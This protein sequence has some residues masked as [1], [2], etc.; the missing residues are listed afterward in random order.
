MGVMRFLDNEQPD[1]HATDMREEMGVMPES[2][3]FSRYDMNGET[4]ADLRP[5]MRRL[6]HQRRALVEIGERRRMRALAMLDV[7]Q[8]QGKDD[9]AEQH[10]RKLMASADTLHRRL[11]E[12]ARHDPDE[13]RVL[14]ADEVNQMARDAPL[15]EREVDRL[16]EHCRR[17]NKDIEAAQVRQM[18]RLLRELDLTDFERRELMAA[19]DDGHHSADHEDPVACT[20]CALATAPG[21]GMTSDHL[22]DAVL[23]S[24]ERAEGNPDWCAAQ[25]QDM[26]AMAVNVP[27]CMG[28]TING[29]TGEFVT[30][31]TTYPADRPM[32]LQTNMPDPQ[33]AAGSVPAAGD[34]RAAGGVAPMAGDVLDPYTCAGAV[35][36]AQP[37]AADPVPDAQFP[38]YTAAGGTRRRSLRVFDESELQLTTVKRNLQRQ[39]VHGPADRKRSSRRTVH[40]RSLTASQTQ[41]LDMFAHKGK[42][43]SY[44]RQ[45][46][47]EQV[48]AMRRRRRLQEEFGNAAP[49]PEVMYDGSGRRLWPQ[50]SQSICEMPDLPRSEELCCMTGICVTEHANPTQMQNPDRDVTAGGERMPR[51][52]PEPPAPVTFAGFVDRMMHEL[53]SCKRLPP[54]E[55]QLPLDAATQNFDLDRDHTLA[56]NMEVDKMGPGCVKECGCHYLGL[57]PTTGSD[58]LINVCNYQ[59]EARCGCMHNKREC[60]SEIMRSW[61]E[62][63]GMRDERGNS[64][65]N[66]LQRRQLRRRN[67]RQ[68]RL[69]QGNFRRLTKFDVK[70]VKHAAEISHAQRGSRLRRALSATEADKLEHF[71]RTFHRGFGSRHKSFRVLTGKTGDRFRQLAVID[72]FH[73]QRRRRLQQGDMTGVTGVHETPLGYHNLGTAVTGGVQVMQPAVAP[74][75]PAAPPAYVDNIVNGAGAQAQAWLPETSTPLPQ[76]P[77]AE[78]TT[79]APLITPLAGNRTA[80]VTVKT[81]IDQSYFDSRDGTFKQLLYMDINPRRDM[82]TNSSAD[83][84]DTLICAT[85]ETPMPAGSAARGAPVTECMN[86]MHWD[87]DVMGYHPNLFDDHFAGTVYCPK[88]PREAFDNHA[89]NE[90]GGSAFETAMA[91]M[92]ENDVDFLQ[93]TP[94]GYSCFEGMAVQE[95]A[96]QEHHDDM[97]GRHTSGEVLQNA[98]RETTNPFGADLKVALT[99]FAEQHFDDWCATDTVCDGFRTKGEQMLSEVEMAF[100]EPGVFHEFEIK[101]RK[102]M[103]HMRSLQTRL[104]TSQGV[105]DNALNEVTERKHGAHSL[106]EAV[107]FGIASGDISPIIDKADDKSGDIFDQI[108]RYASRDVASEDLQWGELRAYHEDCQK[109]QRP[110]GLSADVCEVMDKVLHVLDQKILANRDPRDPRAAAQSAVVTRMELLTTVEQTMPGA[111][112]GMPM[113][114]RMGAGD[115]VCAELMRGDSGCNDRAC[116][117]QTMFDQSGGAATVPRDALYTPNTAAG[118]IRA[119]QAPLLDHEQRERQERIDHADRDMDR[120]RENE[121]AFADGESMGTSMC[122]RMQGRRR[123][124]LLRRARALMAEERRL[125]SESGANEDIEAKVSPLDAHLEKALEEEKDML[126][127]FFPPEEAERRLAALSFDR[128]PSASAGRG[129]YLRNS[130]NL[131]GGV[132]PETGMQMGSLLTDPNGGYI[133]VDPRQGACPNAAALVAA[134]MPDEELREVRE[135]V[136]RVNETLV[137]ARA[138]L[139]EPRPDATERVRQQREDER[140][141]LDDYI[142]DFETSARQV[143]DMART[144]EELRNNQTNARVIADAQA[145]VTAMQSSTAQTAATRPPPRQRPNANEVEARPTYEQARAVEA[146]MDHMRDERRPD[147]ASLVPREARVTREDVVDDCMERDARDSGG[148]VAAAAGDDRARSHERCEQE[149]TAMRENER[150]ARDAITDDRLQNSFAPRHG[151]MQQQTPIPRE[152]QC[153]PMPNDYAGNEMGITRGFRQLL[154]D[155]HRS[156]KRGS[157]R[158]KLAAAQMEGRELY[159][160]VHVGKLRDQRRVLFDTPISDEQ[161]RQ[162]AT[163]SV[164]GLAGGIALPAGEATSGCMPISGE[165]QLQMTDGYDGPGVSMPRDREEALEG[166]GQGDPRMQ[167]AARESGRIAADNTIAQHDAAA[168]VNMDFPNPQD[169]TADDPFYNSPAQGMTPMTDFYNRPRKLLAGGATAAYAGANAAKK[170]GSQTRGRFASK[171]RS[172]ARQLAAANKQ[173][174]KQNRREL[175]HAEL[176]R[177]S[178]NGY[179]PANQMSYDPMNAATNVQPM[180][181]NNTGANAFQLQ[182]PSTMAPNDLTVAQNMYYGGNDPTSPLPTTTPSTPTSS[183]TPYYL[184][185]GYNQMDYLA[186]TAAA[187]VQDSVATAMTTTTVAPAV[188]ANTTHWLLGNDYRYDYVWDEVTQTSIETIVYTG[189]NATLAAMYPSDTDFEVAMTAEHMQGSLNEMQEQQNKQTAAEMNATVMGVFDA[190]MS[191]NG[192]LHVPSYIPPGYDCWQ[193]GT[194]NFVEQCF[195]D[196]YGAYTVQ[197]DFGAVCEHRKYVQSKAMEVADKLYQAIET[198]AYTE[199][200]AGLSRRVRRMLRQSVT[201]DATVPTYVRKLLKLPQEWEFDA[202]R[203]LQDFAMQPEQLFNEMLHTDPAAQSGQSGNADIPSNMPPESMYNMM[204][205]N[206]TAQTESPEDVA[207]MLIGLENS[208]EPSYV[209]AVED[210]LASYERRKMEIYLQARSKPNYLQVLLNLGLNQTEKVKLMRDVQEVVNA[211]E[212]GTCSQMGTQMMQPDGCAALYDEQLGCAAL[213]SV[214]TYWNPFTYQEDV[215]DTWDQPHNRCEDMKRQLRSMAIGGTTKESAPMLAAISQLLQRIGDPDYPSSGFMNLLWK[216]NPR[217]PL[218]GTETA[219][220]H[221][222]CAH[223]YEGT[224]GWGQKRE[225][226]YDD[227]G[228]ALGCDFEKRGSREVKDLLKCPG[229]QAAAAGF[230]DSQNGGSFYCATAKADFVAHCTAVLDF[231]VEVMPTT[232]GTDPTTGMYLSGYLAEQMRMA[233]VFEIDPN[234]KYPWDYEPSE[235]AGSRLARC[236]LQAVRENLPEEPMMDLYHMMETGEISPQYAMEQVLEPKLDNHCN[237]TV[238]VAEAVFQAANIT[239]NCKNF[240]M[241]LKMWQETSWQMQCANRPAKP[242]F[243][244]A[245]AYGAASMEPVC[246]EDVEC[247]LFNEMVPVAEKQQ[248]VNRKVGANRVRERRQRRL[249]IEE[250][251]QRRALKAAE[252]S[253]DKKCITLDGAEYCKAGASAGEAELAKA[254]EEQKRRLEWWEERGIDS[255]AM[256]SNPTKAQRVSRFRTSRKALRKAR[257]ALRRN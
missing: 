97:S 148:R 100:P 21:V 29:T 99:E 245:F 241:T 203:R 67:L 72:K 41:S 123:R 165:S 121:A 211:Q 116:M 161:K 24:A 19:G 81:V 214:A 243:N 233:L 195:D 251:R 194:S 88:D 232:D 256:A 15:D 142:R 223:V 22:R 33:P 197:K 60:M 226:R 143:V 198:K 237:V 5:T 112:P 244:D 95:F 38:T 13:T 28:A 151:E 144:H 101:E 77:A 180:Q 177:L 90:W 217:K 167:A 153:V 250:R 192:D 196:V 79:P 200:H 10:R 51:M 140:E 136:E 191:Y 168:D 14:N 42:P 174:A 216:A 228:N 181:N 83:P 104:G 183:T 186:S 158:R 207:A 235:P 45:L 89:G 152:E 125:L 108:K 127:A 48:E 86:A 70:K 179:V 206:E 159:H 1:N 239:D 35:P 32:T 210:M 238:P 146:C 248:I 54:E 190:Q 176:R 61:E 118:E 134:G 93:N 56:F 6:S 220:L 126:R 132:D 209:A 98:C 37:G 162:L 252:A 184:D 63:G 20:P 36:P 185:F 34:P 215:V 166:F 230:C 173:R 102:L 73:T 107:T 76:M 30:P 16:V 154:E 46:R 169:I 106:V 57:H 78:A 225:C 7:E 110:P 128:A 254:E 9:H 240:C 113:G 149:W 55:R 246:R 212:P 175:M 242:V 94:D 44:S 231:L 257:R 205:P 52:D 39:H 170:V 50:L 85:F 26:Q 49:A 141:Q 4:M 204:T 119:N 138:A 47:S 64:R 189:T 31:V 96:V 224:G 201:A 147:T 208:M 58:V 68:A 137:Q 221:A 182:M 23:N 43:T 129:S 202:K 87:P 71:E 253:V 133:N 115:Y 80:A 157:L 236:A 84:Y 40:G 130:T 229:Q 25:F 222:V 227:C 103:E 62:R 187:L 178:T 66:R 145:G 234:F 109:S 122:E 59:A 139:S 8:E 163:A 155:K 160:A 131:D 156:S 3:E 124:R 219:D 171:P 2:Q 249:S 172:R 164:G 255:I 120:S 218:A 17:E 135:A 65:R 82:P 188:A 11:H 150:G 27:T 114:E 199:A 105:M 111:E 18:N 69:R 75:A 117:E 53:P 91:G 193:H 247:A 213:R 12:V 92:G 74:K